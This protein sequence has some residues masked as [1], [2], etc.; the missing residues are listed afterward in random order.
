MSYGVM[1]HRC[2][3]K[4][5]KNA[6]IVKREKPRAKHPV[7]VH[8]W[9]GI[10]RKGATAACIFEGSMN[11]HMY[12]RILQRTLLP[13]IESKFGPNLEHRFMQDNDPKH[14]SKHASD[15][16]VEN[17]INRWKTP[18]GLCFYINILLIIYNNSFHL[19]RFLAHLS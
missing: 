16:M 17:N 10:S 14:T 5:T 6:V 18:P 15:F 13:F 12:T 19:V 4:D 1:R 9:A 2:G 7:K 11:A 3:L 8:V